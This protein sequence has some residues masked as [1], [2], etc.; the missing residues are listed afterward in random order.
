MQGNVIWIITLGR[1]ERTHGR[2][3]RGRKQQS[4]EWKP[5]EVGLLMR[6]P[7]QPAAVAEQ[8]SRW[9]AASSPRNHWIRSPEPCRVSWPAGRDMALA[10][11][12]LCLQTFQ[13]DDQAAS[14]LCSELQTLPWGRA[15]VWL[16]F[17]SPEDF[18]PGWGPGMPPQAGGQQPLQSSA[19]TLPSLLTAVFLSCVSLE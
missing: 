4:G 11:S 5:E 17:V 3:P 1:F 16:T 2:P 13:K 15:C 19:H 8:R 6:A 7:G 12:L 18:G 14:Y 10:F 9:E